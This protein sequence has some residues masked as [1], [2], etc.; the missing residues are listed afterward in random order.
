LSFRGGDDDH[1]QWTKN[2]ESI[3]IPY[4]VYMGRK[5]VGSLCSETKEC[6]ENLTEKIKKKYPEVKTFQMTNNWSVWCLLLYKYETVTTEQLIALANETNS[7]A[8]RGK[9]YGY[10]EEAGEK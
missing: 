9:L 1:S 6:M 5:P 3:L 7:W 4:L 10:V 2:E 8:E